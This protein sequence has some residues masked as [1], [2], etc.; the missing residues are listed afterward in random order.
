MTN[1]IRLRKRYPNVNAQF[2][3]SAWDDK[4]LQSLVKYDL[5]LD[6]KHTAVTE[7]LC[8]KVHEAGKKVNCWT[9]DTVEDGRR[10][11]GCGVDFI[12]SNILE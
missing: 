8:R 7:E 3:L 6:I 9:V 5:G 10:V 4:H 12:T 2:L 1:L 11:I